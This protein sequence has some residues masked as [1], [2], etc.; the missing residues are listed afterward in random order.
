MTSSAAWNMAWALIAVIAIF[1]VAAGTKRT[2]SIGVL[3]VLIPF[4]QLSTPYASSSVLIAY[5]LAAVL[6]IQGEL[7][8]RLLASISMIVLAYFAIFTLANDPSMRLWHMT[9]MFQFFSCFVVFL[10]AYNFALL[11]KNGRSIF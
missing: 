6:L 5:V 3:L 8:V 9:F 7:K 1:A 2:V 11:I 10:L 4:Q